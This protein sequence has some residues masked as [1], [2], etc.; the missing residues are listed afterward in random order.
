[1]FASED[2]W[3]VERWSPTR[4]CPERDKSQLCQYRGPQPLEPE[5]RGRQGKTTA[6]AQATLPEAGGLSQRSEHTSLLNE[7]LPWFSADTNALA[8]RQ[9]ASNGPP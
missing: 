3:C 5:G 1:M 2:P 6:E 7:L 4:T 8:A 9:A